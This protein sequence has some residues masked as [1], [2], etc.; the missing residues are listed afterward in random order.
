MALQKI[1]RE[2]YNSIVKRGFI[3]PDTNAFDFIDKLFEEAGELEEIVN[4]IKDKK[5]T[6]KMFE[7]MNEEIADVILVCLNFAQHYDIDIEN[8]LTKKIKKNYE[9]A[10]DNT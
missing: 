10:R 6:T 8:E 3:T 2:N 4:E 5:P 9:R 1:I 7:N